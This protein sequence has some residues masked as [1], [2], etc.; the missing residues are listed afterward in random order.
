[1]AKNKAGKGDKNA[2]SRRGRES[3]R[4]EEGN[5]EGPTERGASEH[6]LNRDEGISQVN[7][8]GTFQ[9]ENTHSRRLARRS[10]HSGFALN[11][12]SQR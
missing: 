11:E 7:I 4:D 5:K 3:R 1:M 6:V 8:Q 9:A 12:Q 10:G 2:G